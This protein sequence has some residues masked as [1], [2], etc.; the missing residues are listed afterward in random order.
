M[1]FNEQNTVEHFIIQQLSGVNLNAVQGNVVKEDA[2]GTNIPTDLPEG[3]TAESVKGR[4]NPYYMYVS[5]N[6]ETPEQLSEKVNQLRA[7]GYA[8]VQIVKYD[9]LNYTKTNKKNI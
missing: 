1:A 9:K 2:V 5:G 3:I 4:D 7:H 8:D 6:A